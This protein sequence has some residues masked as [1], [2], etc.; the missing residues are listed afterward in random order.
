[1]RRP[2]LRARAHTKN[3]ES[4]QGRPHTCPLTIRAQFENPATGLHALDNPWQESYVASS[5]GCEAEYERLQAPSSR[6]FQLLA[7]TQV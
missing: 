3:Q 7:P 5:R 1:M 6:N 4:V 2:R